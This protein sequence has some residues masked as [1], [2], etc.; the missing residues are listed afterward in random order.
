[1]RL[2][3]NAT[4]S[5]HECNKKSCPTSVMSLTP[6]DRASVPADKKKVVQMTVPIFRKAF[7]TAP[8]DFFMSEPQK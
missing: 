4:N 2:E 5:Q 7:R 1:M 3:K 6:S 8:H